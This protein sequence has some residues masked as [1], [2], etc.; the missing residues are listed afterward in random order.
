MIIEGKWLSRAEM[1]GRLVYPEILAGPFWDD[2]MADFPEVRI[3][4]QRPMGE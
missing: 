4:A 1:A 2:L 3:L